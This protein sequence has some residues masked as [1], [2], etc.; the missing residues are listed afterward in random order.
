MSPRELIAGLESRGA[1]VTTV[2]VYQWALP[3]DLGPLRRAIEELVAGRIDVLLVTSATQINHLM[4]VAAEQG[5][6]EDVRRGL[7]G[8][9]IASIGPIAT[10]A[11]DSHGLRA[12]LEP[13]H[14]KMGQLVYE[15]AQNAS[16]VLQQKRREG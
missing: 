14:P 3:E 15:A 4:Q 7:R 10:E 6:E 9:F 8:A 12:D 1:Q 16:G 2:P 11:L 5:Q 13:A